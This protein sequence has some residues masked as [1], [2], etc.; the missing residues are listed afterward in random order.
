MKQD[1]WLDGCEDWGAGARVASHDRDRR[2]YSVGGIQKPAQHVFTGPRPDAEPNLLA[3]TLSHV[4]CVHQLLLP[5]SRTRGSPES[6]RIH[7][8][9]L[10]AASVAPLA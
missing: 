8:A 6:Y 2:V 5:K 7:P 4:F 1:G 10:S 3:K 9:L